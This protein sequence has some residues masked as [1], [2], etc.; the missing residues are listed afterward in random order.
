MQ[1]VNSYSDI[2]VMQGADLVHTITFDS[3]FDVDNYTWSSKVAKDKKVT[4]F[5][6]DGSPVTQVVLTIE[7]VDNQS[8]SVKLTGAQTAKFSDDFEGVWDLVSK[9]DSGSLKVR[10]IEGDVLI[11]SGV[12]QTSSDTFVTL[13]E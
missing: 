2:Q 5:T 8:L 3:E 11:S 4:S 12:V 9:A 1:R 10:Q 7:K 13:V 6:Y